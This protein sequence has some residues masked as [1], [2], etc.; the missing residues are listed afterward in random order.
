[1]PPPA[2]RQSLGEWLAGEAEW[3]REHLLPWIA[4]GMRTHPPESGPDRERP[5]DVQTLLAATLP[6]P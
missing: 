5:V 6:S 4:R 3:T 2:P 1:V